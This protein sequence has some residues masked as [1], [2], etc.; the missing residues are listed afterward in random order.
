M[1]TETTFEES[2]VIYRINFKESCYRVDRVN[3][4]KNNR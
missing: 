2:L 4:V 1:K 3:G